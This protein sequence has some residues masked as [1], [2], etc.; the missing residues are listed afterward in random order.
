MD[1]I[2]NDIEHKLK[3]AAG[4]ME[5]PYNEMAWQKMEALLD[6]DKDRRR[7][8]LWLLFAALVAGGLFTFIL[9][10]RNTAEKSSNTAAVPMNENVTGRQNPTGSQLSPETENPGGDQAHGEDEFTTKT[11][12][13]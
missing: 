10:N 4:T 7:P 3:E 13:H 1:K 11:Q 9:V 12:R 5:A 8:I 2:L 6:K